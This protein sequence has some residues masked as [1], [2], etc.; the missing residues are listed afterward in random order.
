MATRTTT[1]FFV[2]PSAFAS[3]PHP[4]TAHGTRIRYADGHECLDGVSGLWNVPLGYGHRGVADAVHHAL[5]DASYLTHFRAGHAWADRAGSALLGA[6]RPGEFTRVLHATSGSAAVDAVIKLAR[7]F[8][9]LRGEPRRRVIVSLHGSYHG[10]TMG[11]MALTGEDLGQR[12]YGVDM[13]G[14]RHVDHTR[15]QD[16]SD[17]LVREGDR[18]AAVVLEPV[19]GSGTRVVGERFLSQVLSGRREHGYL[20]VADEVATGFGRTGPM[21]ASEC[22]AEGPDVLIASKGLTNGTQAASA[23]LLGSRVTN[24][25]D[26]ADSPF[27]HGETQAGTPAACAAI[28]ATIQAFADDHVLSL[29]TAVA[30]QLAS[31]LDDLVR[32]IP[33]A[34]LTGAG[35]FRSI[36]LPG[37]HGTVITELVRDCWEAGAVVQPGPSCIQ[38]VPSL[39]YDE[40][41]LDLLM[42]RVH[43]TLV[44]TLLGRRVAA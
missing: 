10:T 33:G 19:Q 35:C 14:V 3:T 43:Q 27:M 11:A 2:P 5:I 38:I 26:E 15:G 22:W 37:I 13:R 18:I 12:A 44:T 39:V 1:Q 42:D 32:A 24:L 30:A 28:T 4:V 17:L 34:T 9:L 16:L 6:T 36:V 23:I 7:Q 8:Q 41:D 31:R 29:G 20:V 40:A 25:L 21:F